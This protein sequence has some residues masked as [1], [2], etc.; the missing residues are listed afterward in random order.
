MPSDKIKARDTPT[1]YSVS[2]KHLQ[3]ILPSNTHHFLS[4]SFG[5]SLRLVVSAN[6][7]DHDIGMLHAF[8]YGFLVSYVV[9]L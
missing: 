3:Y 5:N 6:K 1:I 4:L 8:G 9:K 7:I 2:R